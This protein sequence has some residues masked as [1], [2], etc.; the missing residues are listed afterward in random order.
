MPKS[1]LRRERKSKVGFDLI[2]VRSV[3]KR[4]PCA[5]IYNLLA[6]DVEKNHAYGSRHS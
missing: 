6:L 5:N 4:L 1:Y 2:F 3:I